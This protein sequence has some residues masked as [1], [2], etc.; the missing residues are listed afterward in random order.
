MKCLTFILVMLFAV[1]TVSAKETKKISTNAFLKTQK[2]IQE[3]KINKDRLVLFESDV[4]YV[5][6][7]FTQTCPDGREIVT[8]AAAFW[9]DC[10][11]LEL[12]YYSYIETGLNCN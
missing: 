1:I 9:F 7:V 11:T 10:E 5:D 8:G 2:K 6:A 3:E 12:F 4:C